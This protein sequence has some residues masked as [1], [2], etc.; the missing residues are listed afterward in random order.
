MHKELHLQALEMSRTALHL[1][2]HRA[3]GRAPLNHKEAIALNSATRKRRKDAD[4]GNIALTGG[5]HIGRENFRQ[6]WL[7]IA[8]AKL[9]LGAGGFM[10]AVPSRKL[11]KKYL[12]GFGDLVIWD[13]RFCVLVAAVDASL[14]WTVPLELPSS[15]CRF[16]F[17]V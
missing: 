16:S 6:A 14:L 10:H 3:Q 13:D 9:I 11:A 1:G 8:L 2:I 4:S 17:R 5:A 7:M 15:M 12:T